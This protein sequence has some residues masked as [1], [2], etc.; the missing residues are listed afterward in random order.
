MGRIAH[1]RPEPSTVRPVSGTA[2]IVYEPGQCLA[3]YSNIEAGG[4]T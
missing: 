3:S 4:R 1:G 2:H